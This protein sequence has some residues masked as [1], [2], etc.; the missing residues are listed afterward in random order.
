[1]NKI[2]IED[3][4]I[5]PV[6]KIINDILRSIK[7]YKKGKI[8][9]LKEKQVLQWIF[10]DKSFLPTEKKDLKNIEDEWG[11]K[12]LKL[13]R[14][15]LTLKKQWTNKFGEHI[16]EELYEILGK[17]PKSATKMNHLVPDLETDDYIVEVKTQT[18]YT[19]G[20]AG[21]KILGTPF[22]YRD[23]PELYKKPLLIVC[24]G[25]AEK[26]CK[27]NYGI[28]SKNKD[29]NASKILDFYKSMGIEYRGITD[30]LKTLIKPPKAKRKSEIIEK[31]KKLDI[32]IKNSSN[33]EMSIKCPNDVISGSSINKDKRHE[34]FGQVAGGSGSR[35]PENFQRSKIVEG[36]GTEC[37]KSNM[38]IN[39]RKNTLNEIS[40]PNKKNNGFD[41]TEDFDGVQ[42]VNNKKI[43]INLK[44]IVGKGGAQTRSLREVYWFIEGQ[45]NV[46]KN[47]NDD[48]YFV[49]IL[50]GDEAHSCMSKFE[51]IFELPEFSS[52][53]KNIYIGDLKGY[54]EWF[55]NTFFPHL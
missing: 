42:T 2:E 11:R 16:A 43:Y 27:E 38:R 9:L 41:Y 7:S 46:L 25:G 31:C 10:D 50:D 15:D 54:F 22:K 21:E 52:V 55:K 20:T 48:V 6:G 29:E 14:P 44:C 33:N 40:H 30:I 17:N 19:S 1:M 5:L 28:L 35:S 37:G 34:L 49:N 32:K 23:V 13:K 12:M 45:L 47:T 36:T 18:Y 4:I 8:V 53:K 26:I 24:V 3:D 51:Y 39:L